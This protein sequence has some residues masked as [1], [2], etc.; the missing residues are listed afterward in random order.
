MLDL[1]QLSSLLT[2]GT[3]LEFKLR[4]LLEISG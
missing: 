3:A 4:A 1:I 2:V